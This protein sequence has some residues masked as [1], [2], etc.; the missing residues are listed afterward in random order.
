MFA[1]NSPQF[2]PTPPQSVG[3]NQ[4]L[5]QPTQ[6]T[7]GG[8]LEGLLQVGLGA[9]TGGL[10]EGL[11]AGEGALNALLGGGGATSPP[12]QTQPSASSASSNIG[13]N[14]QNN[15]NAITNTGADSLASNDYIPELGTTL[16]NQAP[17]NLIAPEA[18]QSVTQQQAPQQQ[19]Q[20]YINP[21]KWE[22]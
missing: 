1:P 12:Q 8:F 6:N 10:T 20:P 15:N 16:A 18:F 4:I 13:N 14:T 19:L 2:N 22:V 11:T 7:G 9:L 3:T 21:Y 17:E 5:N